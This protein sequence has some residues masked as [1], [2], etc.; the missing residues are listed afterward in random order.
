MDMNS[1]LQGRDMEEPRTPVYVGIDVAKAT[2][3]VAWL[4]DGLAARTFDNDLTG[5][6][7]V[8]AELANLNPQLV[9]LEATGGFEVALAATLQAAGIPTAIVNPRQARDFAKATGR[10]AKTDAIDAGV[11]A[12]L[13]HFLVTTPE[14]GFTLKSLPDEATRR[15]QALVARRRQLVGMLTAERNRLGFAH[16]SVRPDIEEVVLFLKK[17]MAEIEAEMESALVKEPGWADRLN[18]LLSVKGIGHTTAAVL[19]ADIPELGTL[20]R[21][22]IS[23][24]IGVAPFNRDSGVLRG[25]RAIFGGRAHV[26]AALYMATLVASRHN[27]V[28]RAFYQRLVNAGKPKKLALV[29]AMRKLLTILNAMAKSGKSWDESLHVA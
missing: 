6:E 12:R 25:K 7:A 21:R 29:A 8:V 11:L 13:A 10:L 15:L 3:D 14:S 24:L 17:R 5:H 19:I 9:I 18:Q 1:H 23:A 28:I 16:A 4:P 2:L 27:D 20:N 22:Q 26:R